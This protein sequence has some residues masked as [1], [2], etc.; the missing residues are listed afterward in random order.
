MTWKDTCRRRRADQLMPPKSGT[1]APGP[2]L[3]HTDYARSAA[4]F[5]SLAWAWPAL[6]GAPR[7]DGHP[8]LVVPGLVTGDA[9]TFVLR[10]F[11]GRLG[12]RTY[13]WGLG[14][15]IGPTAKAV[16]GLRA[17]LDCI[18][19][20]HAQPVSVIGWSLGGIYARQLARRSPDAVR[21]VITLG[22][23]IRLERHRQSNARHLFRHYADRHIERWT[24]PLEDGCGPLPVPATSVYSR[25]D[26]VVAWRACL[27]QPSPR[28]EN[29]EVR[30]SHL[31]FGHHPAVLW[32]VAD[33]LA[34]PPDAWTPF[35]PSRF[36][37]LA[38][39]W[40]VPDP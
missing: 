32:L 9:T 36:T 7:G 19:A 4:E 39:P 37:G 11:L 25:L 22:S 20:R 18:Y 24:L 35:R 14:R 3:L 15:N 21:Q 23:P 10:T 28:A 8:V 16:H 2:L 1:R 17:R 40:P 33:R 6:S 38:Y 27:D 13:G 5:G 31:G 12:Y 26:G 30:A 29:V 34:Q